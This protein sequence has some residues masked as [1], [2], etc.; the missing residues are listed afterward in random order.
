MDY[1]ILKMI[2]ILSA[3]IM[4][5]T[6]LGSAFYLYI[7]YKTAQFSTIKDVVK[8]V[9]LADLIFTTPSV[10]IQFITGILL[11]NKLHLYQ[12]DWF[13]IVLVISFVV[14]ILW[15]VAVYIQ[16]KLKKI[17]QQNRITKTYTKL[18]QIWIYLGGISFV[19][20][21]YLYYLMIFKPFM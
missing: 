17:S 3:T 14:L 19:L 18:M 9:V 2:H 12:T 5:G 8:L 15:L 16:Y 13:K 20:A 10:I 1:T 6:G 21:I 4:I 11:A 7:T